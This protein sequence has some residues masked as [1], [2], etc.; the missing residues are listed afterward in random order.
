MTRLGLTDRNE[1]TPSPE[2][3]RKTW[4]RVVKDMSGQNAARALDPAR[5]PA[6]GPQLA[7]RPTRDASPTLAERPRDP[8]QNTSSPIEDEQAEPRPDFSFIRDRK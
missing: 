2:T 4:S 1:H 7:T 8:A 6:E 3:A 5:K